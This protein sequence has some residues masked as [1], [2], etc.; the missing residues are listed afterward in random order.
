MTQPLALPVEIAAD[1]ANAIEEAEAA[2]IHAKLA[3]SKLG[4]IPGTR[5]DEN[6]HLS[7][8]IT[9]MEDAILRL[10]AAQRGAV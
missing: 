4:A 9:A 8:A 1:I 5:G 10:R 3:R 2:I 7:I 6:R